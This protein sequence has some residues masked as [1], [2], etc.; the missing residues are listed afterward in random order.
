MRMHLPNKTIRNKVLAFLEEAFEDDDLDEAREA[1]QQIANYYQMPEI[2]VF[3]R[4]KFK[5]RTLAGL[6]WEDGKIELLHPI[7]WKKESRTREEWISVALHEF[8][9]AVLWA[10]REAKADIFAEK[11]QWQK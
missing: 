3:F 10:H 2:R 5:K 11:W 6:C 9:H 1:A 8:G 7:E 4:R